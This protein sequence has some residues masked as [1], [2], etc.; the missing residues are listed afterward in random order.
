MGEIIKNP[1][2]II[3][4]DRKNNIPLLVTSESNGSRIFALL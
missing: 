2:C 1:E 4:P 3:M